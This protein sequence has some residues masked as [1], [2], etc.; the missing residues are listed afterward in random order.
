[1]DDMEEPDQN[2]DTS[3]MMFNWGEQGMGPGFTQ[4]QVDGKQHY[5]QLNRN[6]KEQ[7]IHC[8]EFILKEWIYMYLTNLLS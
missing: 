6:K 8:F 1:V 4:E 5:K 3:R 7:K 2:M